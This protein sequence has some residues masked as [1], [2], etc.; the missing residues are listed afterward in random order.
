M[1]E[2]FEFVNV[3]NSKTKMGKIKLRDFHVNN[4]IIKKNYVKLKISRVDKTKYSVK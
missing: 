2:F 1:L 3:I 4:K